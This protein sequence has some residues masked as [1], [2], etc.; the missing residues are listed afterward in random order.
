MIGRRAPSLEVA[1]S[2]CPYNAQ[3]SF[4]RATHGYAHRVLG[5]PAPRS[6]VAQ[7]SLFE[8]GGGRLTSRSKGGNVQTQ[9]RLRWVSRHVY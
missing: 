2:N 9:T 4:Y 7:L 1:I 3:G 5:P 8:V 6:G